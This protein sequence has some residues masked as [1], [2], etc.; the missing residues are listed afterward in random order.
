MLFLVIICM[1]VM[2]HYKMMLKQHERLHGKQQFYQIFI[3][4]IFCAII[5]Q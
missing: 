5:D 2:R 4:T 3:L 1:Q